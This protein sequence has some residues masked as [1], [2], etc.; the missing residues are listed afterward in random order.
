MI[1]NNEIAP[2]GTSPYRNR[3][4]EFVTAVSEEQF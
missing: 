4:G 3:I 1:E 2:R